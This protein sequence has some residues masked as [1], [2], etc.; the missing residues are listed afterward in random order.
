M[1]HDLRRGCGNRRD[2][3]SP[4]R[5]LIFSE[6]TKPILKDRYFPGPNRSFSAWREAPCVSAVKGVFS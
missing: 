6:K 2:A 1:N 5:L 4:G 3:G